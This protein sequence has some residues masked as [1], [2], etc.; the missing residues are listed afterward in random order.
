MAKLNIDKIVKICG[1]DLNVFQKNGICVILKEYEDTLRAELKNEYHNKFIN[2][3][4]KGVD[5]Y[6]L[7]LIFTLHFNEKCKF[8][9]KRLD[10]VM[11]DLNTTVE[12]FTNRQYKDVEFLKMLNDDGIETGLEPFI[13]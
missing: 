5:W 13:K 10:D 12:L 7:A 1:N 11:K 8:G 4:G 6:R 9:Q 2:D 3:L